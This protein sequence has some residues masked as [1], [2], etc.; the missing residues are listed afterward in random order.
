MFT[1]FINNKMDKI[2]PPKD[3][4]LDK[5][6]DNVVTRL[7]EC[8]SNDAGDYKASVA[9]I[10]TTRVINYAIHYSQENSITPEII[11]RIQNLVKEDDLFTDDLKYI[12]VKRILNGNKRKFQPLVSDAVIQD[13]ATK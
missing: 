8:F 9:S 5:S 12:I 10:I 1:I 4:L 11:E 7:K 13:Y 6:Y 2:I 3:V